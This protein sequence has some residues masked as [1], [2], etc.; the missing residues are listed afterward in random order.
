MV[1]S[2]ECLPTPFWSLLLPFVPSVPRCICK[3]MSLN[4]FLRWLYSSELKRIIKN[5]TVLSRLHPHT[6]VACL[7]AFSKFVCGSNIIQYSRLESRIVFRSAFEHDPDINVRNASIE[8]LFKLCDKYGYKMLIT[9]FIT[10]PFEDEFLRRSHSHKIEKLLGNASEC[11][12][13]LGFISS[14][15]PNRVS[16]G[17][18]LIRSFVSLWDKSTLQL[19]RGFL[20][21]HDYCVRLEAELG[22]SAYSHLQRGLDAGTAD[23]DADLTPR[24][25]V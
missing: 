8:M 9:E 18:C 11:E 13:V 23:Q 3:L 20:H 1:V 12:H 2:I 22:I 15:S 25:W 14:N 21:S 24:I 7:K 17:L 16:F 19:V 10:T 4:V 6:R 5:R